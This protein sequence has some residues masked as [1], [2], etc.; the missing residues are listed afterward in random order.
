MSPTSRTLKFLRQAGWTADIVERWIPAPND[1]RDEKRGP[2]GF[3]R[4]LFGFADIIA[5]WPAGKEILLI[6]A[7]SAA[8][9]SARLEKSRQQLTLRAWLGAGGR[10]EVW[11]WHKADGRWQVRRVEVR[12]EELAGVE[13]TPKR[14]RQKKTQQKTLFG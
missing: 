7:T 12:G 13:L 5:V 4:D 14:P 8:N 9:V 10:F 1:N 6:Q 11:G 2:S 3:R